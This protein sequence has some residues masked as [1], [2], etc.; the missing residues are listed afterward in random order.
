MSQPW[1]EVGKWSIDVNMNQ[2]LGDALTEFTSRI[3]ERLFR[4]ITAEAICIVDSAHSASTVRV[5]GTPCPP[6]ERQDEDRNIYLIV[7]RPDIMRLSPK[8]ALGQVAHQFAHLVLRLEHGVDSES[9][10]AGEEMADNL[11]IGWG[12]KEEIGANKAER[13]QLEDQGS[14][15]GQGKRHTTGKLPRKK[16]AAST[17]RKSQCSSV[18]S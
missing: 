17:A 18:A 10:P 12:F 2:V 16:R 7:F 6:P 11:A 3:D 1:Y 4:R 5:I 8:A 13:K 14:A 15:A 9:L